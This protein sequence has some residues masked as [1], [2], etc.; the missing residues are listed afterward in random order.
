VLVTGVSGFVG[1]HVAR[2]CTEAGAR[3]H[4]LGP[5][6]AAPDV[7]GLAVWHQANV[8]DDASLVDAMRAAAPDAVVHLAGQSSA[9]VSFEQPELTFRL[10][11][12]G[13]WNV[14]EAVRHA[15][16]RARVLVIGTS[17]SYGPQPE[18]SRVAEDAPFQPVSPYGLSKAAADALAD[19]HTR[20][21]GLDVIRTRSFAH[22]GPGQTPRFVIPSFAEQIARIE[23]GTAEPVLRVGNLQVTRDMLDVRDVAL[24]YLALIERGIAGRAYN[25]CRGEGVRLADLVAEMAAA[26]RKPVR[27]EVDPA[28]QRPADVPYLVGDPSR[29]AADT[30]WRP[31]RAL[32]D[33]VADVL[34]EWRAAVR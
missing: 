27:I 13:T 9:A 5:E 25:V 14:L 17:E 1:P 22:T 16:P 10:N 30:G 11:A 4:G 8:L 33:T 23:A 7:A 12:L 15:A 26:A 24:A 34:A 18:G 20:H 32:A 3:V 29:L 21:Y 2:V 28:R 6:S 19:A 31:A